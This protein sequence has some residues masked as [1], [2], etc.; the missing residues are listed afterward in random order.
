MASEPERSSL[1]KDRRVPFLIHQA[2]GQMY[3]MRREQVRLEGLPSL[4]EALK[5]CDQVD[6][7][8]YGAP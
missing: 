8:I 5:A 6:N 3:G 1:P 4:A 7:E 2:Q